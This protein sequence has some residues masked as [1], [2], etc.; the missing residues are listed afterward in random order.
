MNILRTLLDNFLT[1][2]KISIVFLFILSL[3]NS[4]VQSTVISFISANIIESI[5]KKNIQSTTQ[6]LYQFIGISILFLIFY[7]FYKILQNNILT[8][9]TQWIKKEILK[10]IL[11]SNNEDMKHV[12]FIEF[13]TPITRISSSC[14]VLAFSF[15]NIIIPLLAFLMIV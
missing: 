14:Y 5:E 11:L 10:I 2:E 9:M 3:L 4:L 13:I 15:I 12:N 7:Y 6:F 8:K 1:E